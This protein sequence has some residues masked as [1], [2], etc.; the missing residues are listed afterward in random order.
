MVWSPDS[1]AKK[2]THSDPFKPPKRRDVPGSG[3]D[4]ESWKTFDGKKQTTPKS[5]D[6]DVNRISADTE[7]QEITYSPQALRS[8]ADYLEKN[9]LPICN[10]GIDQARGIGN[11]RTGYFEE[12]VATNKYAGDIE[13]VSISN[14]DAFKSA[15]QTLI[16]GFRDTARDYK[17]ANE[18]SE[19]MIDKLQSVINEVGEHLK[20]T[21]HVQGH[22]DKDIQT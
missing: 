13:T 22:N 11:V 2:G 10:K 14:C 3:F 1:I 15:I 17:T 8:Y 9:V 5:Q 12:G 19:A 16:D 4:P 21:R 20:D 7:G 6:A 18:E